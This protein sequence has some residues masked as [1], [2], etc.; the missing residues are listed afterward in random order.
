MSGLTDLSGIALRAYAPGA[1]QPSSARGQ[2]SVSDNAGGG[3]SAR[4]AIV[5]RRLAPAFSIEL[6]LAAQKAL[7]KPLIDEEIVE[8]ATTPSASSSEDTPGSFE[9][10]FDGVGRREVPIAAETPRHIAPGSRLNIQV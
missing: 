10:L 8:T 2:T 3:G 6:S 9:Q 4:P 5:D 7:G 1:K